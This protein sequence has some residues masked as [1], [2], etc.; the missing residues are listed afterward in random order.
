MFWPSMF[1]FFV[2]AIAPFVVATVLN[3][4]GGDSLSDRD[5]SETDGMGSTVS[6]SVP[7]G[8]V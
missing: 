4:L 5:H 6:G 3:R 2:L 7:E 8:E 1:V